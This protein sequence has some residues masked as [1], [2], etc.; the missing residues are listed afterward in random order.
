MSWFLNTLDKVLLFYGKSRDRPGF[1]VQRGIKPLIRL[2]LF[3][4]EVEEA[5][6]HSAATPKVLYMELKSASAKAS[7]AYSQPAT[8]IYRLCAAPFFYFVDLAATFS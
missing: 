2:S 6:L 8:E 5:G 7:P 4:L 3:L 1:L